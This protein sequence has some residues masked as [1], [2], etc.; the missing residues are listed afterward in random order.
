[1]MNAL[2]VQP[3]KYTENIDKLVLSVSITKEVILT[4][5]KYDCMQRIQKYTSKYPVSLG[6]LQYCYLRFHWSSKGRR[7][8]HTG[9]TLAVHNTLLPPFSLVQYR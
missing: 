4:L 1:M 3:N 6:S 5:S 8:I 7:L 9:T 2:F